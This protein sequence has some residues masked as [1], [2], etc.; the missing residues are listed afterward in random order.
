MQMLHQGTPDQRQHRLVG[1]RYHQSTGWRNR[2]MRSF[3]AC[4]VKAFD[5]NPPVE[6]HGLLWYP[7]QGVLSH[8]FSTDVRHPYFSCCPPSMP[9]RPNR[10]CA[11]PGKRASL[12]RLMTAK[13]VHCT[14]L[15]PNQTFVA[16]LDVRGSSSTG[17]RPTLLF[18]RTRERKFG[19]SCF[20]RR[21]FVQIATFVTT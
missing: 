20:A 13:G 4:A 21:K 12:C 17:H 15:K 7:A 18:R 10:P 11:W 16:R 8:Q 1:H 19:W 9:A 2:R 14:S 5:L 6:R 3:R